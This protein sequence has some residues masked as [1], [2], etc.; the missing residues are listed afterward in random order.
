MRVS[1]R[2]RTQRVKHQTLSEKLVKEIEKDEI[3]EIEEYIVH[4]D[5][6]DSLDDKNLAEVKNEMVIEETIIDSKTDI[7]NEQSAEVKAIPELEDDRMF[8]DDG[9]DSNSENV[10]AIVKTVIKDEI[11]VEEVKINFNSEQANSD[12]EIVVKENHNEKKRTQNRTKTDFSGKKAKRFEISTK[13]FLDP[14]HWLKINLT[15]EEALEEFRARAENQKY[16]SAAYKCSD[17]Y[18]GFSK[19]DMLN[20]H[21]K[22]RH[23][24]VCIKSFTP[25]SVLLNFFV[26][27]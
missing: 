12:E 8:S 1:N 14:N 15:E 2:V 21:I 22:L 7:E 6:E 20:R 25:F 27:Q 24:E 19:E 5:S 17:C 16:V 18:K 10:N 9:G 3:P 23:S 13:N 11:N 4:S 26:L